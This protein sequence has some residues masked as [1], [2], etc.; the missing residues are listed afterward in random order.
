MKGGKEDGR[1]GKK[2]HE[3][4]G[5]KQGEEGKRGSKKHEMDGGRNEGDIHPN[6]DKDAGA[7][8]TDGAEAKTVIPH[9]YDGDDVTS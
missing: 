2:G 5:Q 1:R 3:E 7:R 6:G 9:F 4:E 8:R